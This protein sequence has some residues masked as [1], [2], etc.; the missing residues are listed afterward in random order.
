MKNTAR[1]LV[2]WECNLKCSY[3]CN[4]QQ[5]FREDIHPVKLSEID[6]SKYK[7]VCIS[8]GEPLLFLHK[9]KQVCDKAVSSVK[10][11]YSNGLLWNDKTADKL[12]DFG[13]TA[14][15]IGLH[16]PKSF[17][18]VIKN[19]S[20]S[21]GKLKIRFHVWNK[22]EISLAHYYPNVSFRFWELDDCDRDNEDRFVLIDDNPVEKVAA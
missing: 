22:Y 17:D 2:D 3:C 5:R 18:S 9:V 20:A 4:E 14:V 8:G 7:I 12:F 1:V 16:Y 10:I 6:F 19:V 15:N 11:L 13:I 21:P